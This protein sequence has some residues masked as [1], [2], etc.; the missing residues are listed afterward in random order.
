LSNLFSARR[1]ALPLARA[2]VLLG[3]VVLICVPALTRAGQRFQIAS[4][5][6]SFAKN[7]DCPPR[8]VTVAPAPAVVSP[9]LLGRCEPVRIAGLAP[10]IAAA[11]P[12]SPFL[13]TPSPLRAPP[14]TL[15]A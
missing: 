12:R 15:L 9:A 11:R 3:V 13:S 1:H 4:Q 10:P 5:A 14:S 7:I 2:A 6:P 8:K